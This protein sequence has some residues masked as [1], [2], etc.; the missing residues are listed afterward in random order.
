LGDLVAL[1]AEPR[2][3]RGQAEGLPAQLIGGYQNYPHCLYYE[4]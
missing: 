1:G 4:R 2:C 3:R